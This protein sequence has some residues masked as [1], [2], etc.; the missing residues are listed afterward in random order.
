M[1]TLIPWLVSFLQLIRIQKRSAEGPPL[2]VWQS[3]SKGSRPD[4][5]FTASPTAPFTCG[6]FRKRVFLPEESIHWSERHLRS[7]LAHEL[8]HLDR[9]DPLVRLCSLFIRALFWFHPL[10]WF[11][12]RQLILA[13]E[14]ACDQETLKHGISAADYAEDLLLFATQNRTSPRETLAM[15]KPSQLTRRVRSILS[16]KKQPRNSA[17]LLAGILLLLP[18]LSRPLVLPRTLNPPRAPRQV[19]HPIL[20]PISK[21]KNIS[22]KRGSILTR[23]GI[24]LA[25]SD[26]LTRHY[27]LKENTPHFIGYV[28]YNDAYPE[29]ILSSDFEKTYN[30]SL[31][32]GNSLSLTIDSRIQEASTR[33]LK[34]TNQTGAIIVS[35]PNTGAILAMASFPNYDPNLFPSGIS[36]EDSQRLKNDPRAPFLNRAIQPQASGQCR[37]NFDSTR[38]PIQRAQESGI[39]SVKDPF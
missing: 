24:V 10:V 11:A 39:T 17:A 15:A 8:S 29:M 6:V 18:L 19:S 3:L 37:K 26:G 23:D 5:F 38:E 1:L 22:K 14:E 16:S 27:P 21:T 33:I 13:Q 32:K 7:A 35:D 4:L 28:G 30:D 20:L 25:K 2:E 9:K 31:T 12:H 36:T 34:Q